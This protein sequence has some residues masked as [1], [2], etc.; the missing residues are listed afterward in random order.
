MSAPASTR[1]S[2]ETLAVPVREQ[3]VALCET[4]LAVLDSDPANA[5]DRDLAI[6]EMRVATKRLRA[7]WHLVKKADAEIAKLRRNGLRLLSAEIAGQRDQAVLLELAGSLAAENPEDDE[8]FQALITSLQS[9]ETA[10]PSAD[11]IPTALLRGGWLEELNAWRNLDLGSDRE[12][13]RL[14]RNA[15]RE[16]QT[17]ALART[18]LGLA[19]GDAEIWHDWRKAVKRLRY[20]REFVASS[21]G[22]IPGV[23][24]ARISR[25][26]TRLGERNDLANLAIGVD[27][28]LAGDRLTN[29]QHGRIRKA[30]ARRERSI[31]GNARRLGRLA[32]LR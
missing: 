15:L 17:L 22:R 31:L 6:H 32:F 7:A 23:R 20:Q 28:C 5:I 10:E 18:K 3:C 12:Q 27:A 19:D 26:G 25:L 8:A 1:P 13:R 2:T 9:T 30:I 14:I 4:C 24:D 16:S 11:D 21:Q 29:H